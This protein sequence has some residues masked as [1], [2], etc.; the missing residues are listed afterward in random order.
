MIKQKLFAIVLLLSLFTACTAVSS[1]PDAI[2][3]GYIAIETLA[4]QTADSQSL[5]S[6]QKADLRANLQA[7]K[8]HLDT[9][10]ELYSIGATEGANNRLTIA[11]QIL[12]IVEEVLR[13]GES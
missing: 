2:G 8:D 3:S 10:T 1:L 13:N 9:A 7:A 12:T 6:E 11:L 5:S 4:D